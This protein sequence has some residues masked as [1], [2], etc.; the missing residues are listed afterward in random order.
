M[1]LNGF[2]DIYGGT[3]SLGIVFEQT[4]GASSIAGFVDSDYV[5]DLNKR[6]STTG[7][8]FILASGSILWRSMLQATSTLSRTEEEYI[9]LTEVSKEAIW[10]KGLVSELCLK[11]KSI[12]LRC[13]S[14]SEVYLAKNQ[15]HHARTKH[16]DVRYH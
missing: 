9:A 3:K 8:V 7:Y 5:R 14:Q 2:F 11:R 16:I 1:Q 10:L 6:R 12:L 13:D 4:Y 15:V